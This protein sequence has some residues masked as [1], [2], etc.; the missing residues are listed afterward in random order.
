MPLERWRP[1]QQIRDTQRIPIPLG[2]PPGAYTIYVGAFRGGG[3]LPVT[4][5]ALTDGKDR[6]R[7]GTFLVR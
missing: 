4:P 3:R 2:S 7:V 5:A 6:L 1:G